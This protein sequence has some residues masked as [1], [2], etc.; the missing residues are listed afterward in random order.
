MG[1]VFSVPFLG[2]TS[3]AEFS[4]PIVMGTSVVLADFR[5]D[6]DGSPVKEFG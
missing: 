1:I 4:L 3:K 6:F 2:G 5:S